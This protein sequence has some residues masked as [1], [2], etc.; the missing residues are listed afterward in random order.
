MTS[1]LHLPDVTLF[2]IDAHNPEGI[3]RAAEISQRG[4]EFGD[5]VVITER[6]FPGATIQEGRTNYS[7]FMIKELTNYFST[8][9]VLSIHA[10]GY[11]VNPTAWD[12]EWLNWDYGGGTWG[13]K[14]GMNVGNGGFSLRSK[15]LCD[16]LAKDTKINQYFPE[17]DKIC[18][19]YR[20]Y[21]EYNYGINFMP[22]ELA[23]R[24]SI[25]AY[26][27]KAFPKGNHY[28][29]QFG[30]HS[31]HVDFSESDIPKDIRL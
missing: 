25:E 28:S 6:L 22:E 10:D 26:G 29:G 4:I 7:K 9:H 14:D 23:N 21:L 2:S 3:K 19:T 8:S 31:V 24:F 11:V 18:R 15:K 13:Y 16:I 20:R 17:D 12:D 5:V 27:A 1:K 30:F